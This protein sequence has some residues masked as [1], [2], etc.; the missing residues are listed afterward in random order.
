MDKFCKYIYA[1]DST[2]R[3]RTRAIL[4]HIY[5]HAIHDNWF[6]ARD[7]MLMSHLQ[8]SISHSDP[9]TQILYNRTMVQ[10]G[11]CGFRHA[12]IQDA[13][14]ALLDIQLGG[15]SKELLAQGLLPQV[16]II[17]SSLN[18]YTIVLCILW[19][20]YWSWQLLIVQCAHPTSHWPKIFLESNII[21]SIKGY[22]IIE[23]I[24]NL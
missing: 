11:L 21:H 2:D 24:I 16:T 12:Q 9:P 7:L 6:E 14:N 17:C 8:D 1:K 13:H 15:R 23:K 10:L 4:C 20:Y 3:L 19:W 22:H 18:A 5:H